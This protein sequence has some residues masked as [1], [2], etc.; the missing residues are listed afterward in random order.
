M[1]EK[2]IMD[3]ILE[4]LREGSDEPESFVDIRWEVLEERREDGKLFS[5]RVTNERYPINL[6][7]LD[8]EA[9][10]ESVKAVRLVI[11][12]GVKT[13]DLDRDEKLRLYRL[14]L[15]GAKVPFAAFYLFGEED[16]IGVAV[17]LDKRHITRDEL[18]AHL[19]AL[20]LAYAMLSRVGAIRKQLIRG[21]MAA[22][23]GLVAAWFREGMTR[24]QAIKRLVSGGVDRKLA[25]EAVN[26]IFSHSGKEEK[27]EKEDIFWL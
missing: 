19:A 5:F 16:E 10:D 1:A 18:E 20:F 22:L 3:L 6:L 24:E 14:L 7:V 12:T 27:Q 21:Q 25:E 8:L 11:E 13:I 15:E 9:L 23:L 17:D 2:D 4:W 26:F